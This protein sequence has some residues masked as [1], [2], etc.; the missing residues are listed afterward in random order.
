MF[1]IL[2]FLHPNVHL[3]LLILNKRKQEKVKYSL[4]PDFALNFCY[5]TESLYLSNYRSNFDGCRR[6]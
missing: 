4:P 6:V 2:K 1:E 3:I 5:Q